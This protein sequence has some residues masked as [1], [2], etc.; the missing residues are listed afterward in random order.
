[1]DDSVS[2]DVDAESDFDTSYAEAVPMRAAESGSVE[3][4][5]ALMD[6]GM[7]VN[8]MME[9]MGTPIVTAIY[10]QH[11]PLIKFLL[12]NGAP[13]HDYEWFPGESLL[14]NSAR[15]KTLDIMKLLLEHGAK[16][17]DNS[18]M[19]AAAEEGN[20]PAL[21]LLMQRGAHIDEPYFQY[22]DVEGSNYGTPLHWAVIAEQVETVKFLL[23][24]GARTDLKDWQ[25]DTARDIAVNREKDCPELGK[26]IDEAN[27]KRRDQS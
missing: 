13:A 8:I 12:E 17:N 7:S 16:A 2:F 19:R 15:F 11:V 25:G 1:M 24:N 27:A 14:A 4:M 20:I 6:A 21:K 9:K 26:L 22:G 23:D 3:V 18:S 10:R 5:Q